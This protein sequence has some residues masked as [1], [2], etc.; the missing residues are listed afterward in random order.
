MSYLILNSK[1]LLKYIPDFKIIL[2]ALLYFFSARLGYF[3]AF[4]DTTALPAWPPSGV[5]FALILLL[6]RSSWP[7][8]AIGALVANLMAYW[9]NQALAQLKM[10]THS[11]VPKKLSVSSL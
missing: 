4:P 6:G 11:K 3:L 10:I 2:A 5:A 8:I 9:N 1:L 7:G